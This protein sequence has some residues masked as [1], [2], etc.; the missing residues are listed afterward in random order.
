[1]L[2]ILA[3]SGKEDDGGVARS[4]ALPDQ[5]SGLKTVHARHHYVQQD[6]CEIL[7]QEVAEGLAARLRLDDLLAQALQYGLGGQQVIRLI[8]YQQ[9][10]DF[11]L[12]N[13]T[14]GNRIH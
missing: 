8:V 13:R 5:G 11:L 1:M 12:R 7:I 10:L 4:L 14:G 6:Y 9:D 2:V 3:E